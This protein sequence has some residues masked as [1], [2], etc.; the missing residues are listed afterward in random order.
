MEYRLRTSRRRRDAGGASTDGHPEKT[1]TGERAEERA[2]PA[3]NRSATAGTDIKLVPEAMED[4]QIHRLPIVD[5]E[6]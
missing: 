2:F 6:E 3:E 5:E 4:Y 1:T